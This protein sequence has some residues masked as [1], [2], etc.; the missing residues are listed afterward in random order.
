M[1]LG[2][3]RVGDILRTRPGG[4]IAVD[5]TV[6]SGET[7]I[8]ESML[9]GEPIPVL[10]RSGDSV[11]AGTLT[12]TGTLTY[13]AT[14]VGHD[15]VLARITAL[16]EAAQ[17]A[18]LPVE[19]LVNRITAW[20]VPVVMVIA[21]L[22]FVVWW[23]LAG[24]GP[25]VVAGVSVLIIACPCAMGLATP[26][27]IMVGTGRAAE[28]GVLFHKGAALQRLQDAKVIAFDK[29]GTLTVGAPSVTDMAGD[30]TA[31]MLRLAAGVEQNSEHPIARAIVAAAPA[32]PHSVSDFD[33]TL[34]EGAEAR[35]DGHHV[36]IGNPAMLDRAGIAL[37]DT[38]ITQADDWAATGVTPVHVAIN[39]AHVGVIAISDQIRTGAAQTIADIKATGRKVAMISGDAQATANHVAGRLGID[40][41]VAN[42]RPD[43]KVAA[44]A[45]LRAAHGPVAFVGDGIND[46]PALAAADVGLAVNGANDAAIEAA[47]VVMM[48]PE[49]GA[50]LRALTISAATLRNIRQNLVWAFGYNTLLIPVAA[51]VLVPFG[52]PQLS[53]ALAALAMAL[54]SVF[55]V[56]N[57]CGC[58]AR[59]RYE[60]LPSC[61]RH[62]AAGQNDPLLRRNRADP[63][64]AQR[65]RIPH[66]QRHRR[67]PA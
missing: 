20:F 27:S 1:Q 63:T 23:A 16:T 35:V 61:R 44:I 9:T 28:L 41:V 58:A 29:T 22:A 38:W 32:L 34:G 50:V 53:P 10:K 49:P 25:A 11:S 6:I 17:A 40:H 51:G 36:I 59:G 67:A 31:L 5:G 66:V 12:T 37:E 13:R 4:R 64:N 2:D 56:T 21:T 3:V 45:A 19:A 48:S 52:G 60:H 24:L 30:E 43:G 14:H 42:V 62:R 33:A 39:G 18:R 55:V 15:T 57:A 7:H 65:Q 26:M 47:D 46:A 54:S 8:D